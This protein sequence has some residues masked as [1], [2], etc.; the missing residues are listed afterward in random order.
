[1]KSGILITAYKHPE[2]TERTIKSFRNDF[3]ILNN[4]PIVVVTTSEID[5]GFTDFEK[6]ENV[7]VIEYRDVP[8]YKIDSHIDINMQEST[9]KNVGVSLAKRIF[10]SIERGLTKLKELGCD[11]CINLH[12]D[13]YWDYN[14]EGMLIS[15]FNT[16]YNENLLLSGDLCLEDSN[17]PIPQITHWHPEGLIININESI[18][19][20]FNKLHKIWLS[21]FITHNWG[22]VEGLIGQFAVYSLTGISIIDKTI[23]L[24]NEYLSKVKVRNIRNYHGKFNDGLI[25]ELVK[26]R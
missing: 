15:Y 26:Q 14:K 13:T 19:C 8:P 7:Y 25:N 17:S 3:K 12:G 21:N 22:S 10:L 6:Y 9:D 1:M 23:P 2:L 18:K 20:E 16:V 4:I 5:V 11:V 24:P